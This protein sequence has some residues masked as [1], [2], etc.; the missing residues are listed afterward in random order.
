MKIIF[1]K[2][3]LV[4]VVLTF[5]IGCATMQRRWEATKSEDTIQAYKEFLRHYPEVE[6]ADKAHERLK[7]LYEE[8]DWE[9]SRK[10]NT[11]RSYENF[12]KLYQESRFIEVARSRIE[13]LEWIQAEKIASIYAYESFITKYP[14]SKFNNQAKEKLE[15]LEWVSTEKEDSIEAYDSFITKYPLSKY[16]SQA[17]DKLNLLIEIKEANTVNKIEE[18][19]KKYEQQKQ[20]VRRLVWS[21][22]DMILEKIKIKGYGKRL[23]I[24]LDPPR[25]E[26]KLEI[27]CDS[28]MCWSSALI[29]PDSQP[30][31]FMITMSESPEWCVLRFNGNVPTSAFLTKWVKK[32][33]W[34]ETR[35]EYP[36]YLFMGEGEYPNQLTFGFIK[37]IGYIYLRGKGKVIYPNGKMVKFL[38]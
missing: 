4:A 5:V 2:L 37:G 21:V 16:S 32:Q 9:K 26:G 38:Q 25:F 33:S 6:L 19:I 18:L 7:Q 3:L 15:K 20:L 27:S 23:A 29:N 22:E 13:E 31:D 35:R 36:K 17:K 28:D 11:I 12:L 10:I 30:G 24:N 34:K 8:R 14:N 1:S